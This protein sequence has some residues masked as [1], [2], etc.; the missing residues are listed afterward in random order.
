[1]DLSNVNLVAVLVAALVA[2]IVGW[3]WYGPL[4]GKAWMKLSGMKASKPKG[5]SIVWGYLT[6]AV[7]AYVLAVLMLNFNVL[8]M[9]AALGLAFW[10]WLGFFATMNLGM[11]I[12]EDKKFNLYLINT[13]SGLL[14]LLIMAGVL[15][16]MM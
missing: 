1:M 4:F 14:T 3:L 7:M 2:F 9:N 5:S 8:E 10:I 15:S 12:W 6:H 11:V 13:G 16:K